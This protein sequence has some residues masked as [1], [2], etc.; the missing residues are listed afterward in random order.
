V[1]AKNAIKIYQENG[2]YHIYNR[3][4]AKSDI[5]L[6]ELD[7]NVFLHY[8]KDY[9]SPPKDVTPEQAAL[10][11]TPYILKNYN[12][13]IKLIA[14]CLM[15]NHF[16]LLIKQNKERAIEGLM[17]S[18][19][20]RYTSFFN[21][22]HQRVGHVFQGVYKAKLIQVD[23]YFW[24]LSRYIHR[25]PKEVIGPNQSLATYPYSSYQLYLGDRNTPWIHSEEITD[26][27]KDYRAFVEGA[28]EKLPE[29]FT[30]LIIE[31]KD[32]SS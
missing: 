3:G 16:H 9:L 11:H 4:V 21:K 13:E 22:N 18:L 1:P 14:Y 20:I 31:E 17:R 15:P 25:N 24:W 10:M 12:L 32:S 30:D 8:L 19:L 2:Y 28:V 5:F 23:E 7:Y 27:I 29:N 6:N 26:N